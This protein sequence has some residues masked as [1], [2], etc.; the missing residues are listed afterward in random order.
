MVTNIGR[1]TS[2]ATNCPVANRTGQDWHLPRDKVS[3][4]SSSPTIVVIV[5]NHRWGFNLHRINLATRA[6]T[7]SLSL[8]CPLSECFHRRPII[9]SSGYCFHLAILFRTL[10]CYVSDSAVF[11]SIQAW[12][13]EWECLILSI[14]S[15]L[16]GG[17]RLSGRLCT[18]F[19]MYRKNGGNVLKEKC[20]SKRQQIQ[21]KW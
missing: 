2:E 4:S 21:S 12:L 3:S 19:S 16:S 15:F 5:H 10:Y 13:T 14:S 9:P 11:R 6:S 8:V 7:M 20:V 18:S 1:R 17:R